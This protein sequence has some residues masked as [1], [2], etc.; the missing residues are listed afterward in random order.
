MTV[1]PGE[2]VVKET[3]ADGNIVTFE[4]GPFADN[5]RVELQYFPLEPGVVT[6]AWSMV[7]WQETPAYYV[8]VDARGR[9]RSVVAEEHHKRSDTI[10]H[11]L[12]LQRRQSGTTFSK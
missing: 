6:E 9:W 3:S 11:L 7:L 8:F 1:D 5:I 2:L 10:S 12:G 4:P